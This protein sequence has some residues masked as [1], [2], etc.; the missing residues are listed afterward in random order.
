MK[1][2]KPQP[3]PTT[4][5]FAAAAGSNKIFSHVEILSINHFTVSISWYNYTIYGCLSSNYHLKVLVSV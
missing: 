2:V 3:K 5:F 1:S 4:L